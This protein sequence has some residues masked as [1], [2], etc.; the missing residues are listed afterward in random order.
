MGGKEW[1]KEDK[2]FAIDNLGKMDYKEMSVILNRTPDAIKR[3]I[4]YWGLGQPK[5][6]NIYNILED[7]ATL[8]VIGRRGTYVVKIDIEDVE[9]L[10]KH[11]WNIQGDNGYLSARMLVNGKSSC[12]HLHRLILNLE[13]PN[14]CCDH[15]SMDKTDNRK[16]NL[17][18]CTKA[19]N[20]QNRS[21]IWGQNTTGYRGVC[22][23]KN[24]FA[25]K[26]KH[27]GKSITLKRGEKEDIE[28]LAKISSFARAY[29][30]PFSEDYNLIKQEEIPQWIKDR[31]DDNFGKVA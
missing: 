16:Y 4:S 13:D 18:E 14:I 24:K 8:T 19:E 6:D 9:K 10:K 12:V 15:I 2:Q 11:T 29:L 26:I 27:K 20:N 7:Y 22:K 1:T 28:K 5:A 23:D 17:R 25:A 21:H 31:L 3:K 30:F